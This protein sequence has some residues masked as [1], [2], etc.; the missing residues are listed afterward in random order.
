MSGEYMGFGLNT[1]L[2]WLNQFCDRVEIVSAGGNVWR[3]TV[4]SDEY[5]EYERT[6]TLFAI[7]SQAFKP[8]K[9]KAI[10]QRNK[11]IAALKEITA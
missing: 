6:G 7:V 1:M 5:G 10:E 2:Y 9:D 8:F 11:N 3:I 4:L